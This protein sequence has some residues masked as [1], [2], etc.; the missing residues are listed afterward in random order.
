MRQQNQGRSRSQPC[1]GYVP[2]SGTQVCV[3]AASTHSPAPPTFHWIAGMP[4]RILTLFRRTVT[5]L[6]AVHTRP[7]HL[8]GEPRHILPKCGDRSRGG[9]NIHVARGMLGGI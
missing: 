6:H 9:A 7:Q 4:K 8:V 1:E 5:A 3:K 2:P